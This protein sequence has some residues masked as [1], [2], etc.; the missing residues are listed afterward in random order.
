MK[1]DEKFASFHVNDTKR[2][3]LWKVALAQRYSQ[4]NLEEQTE[5]FT[6]D[7]EEENDPV[8]KIK[9][10]DKELL[11]TVR[12][13]SSTKNI[14]VQGNYIQK[15]IDNEWPKLDSKVNGELYN[16]I[17]WKNDWFED[18]RDNDY[19]HDKSTTVSSNN[20]NKYLTT[21]TLAPEKRQKL[22]EKAKTAVAKMEE[23]D[24]KNGEEFL[25]Q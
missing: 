2:L 24:Q 13:F 14:T 12:I 7:I 6:A 11:L 23:K 25:Q 15:W 9:S 5:N 3:S 4:T 20:S 22:V 19:N 17:V 16:N 1:S 10:T 21:I 8:I 18:T